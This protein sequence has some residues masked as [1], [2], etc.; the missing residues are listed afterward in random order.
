ET[1]VVASL[2]RPG[3]N[4]TGLTALQPDL[5]RKR[6]DLLKEAL[7]SL[8]RIAV[9]MSPY[10]AAPS[11][12]EPLLR[13]TE[14]AAAA[15]R[16]RVQIVRVEDAADLERSFQAATRNGTSAGIILPNPFWGA[17]ATRVGALA[18]RHRLPIMAQDP[19]IVEAGGL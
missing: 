15:L 12:G 8:L 9:L 7:P 13:E 16:L 6:L 10:R 2:A 1:G 18:L 19:G 5:S 4:V 14:A 17:N 3:G 11:V